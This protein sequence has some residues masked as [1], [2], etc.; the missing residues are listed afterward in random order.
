M[1]FNF[2]TLVIVIGASLVCLGQS[3]VAGPRLGDVE[4]VRVRLQSEADLERFRVQGFNVTNA[5]GA[6]AE[7]HTT[8]EERARLRRAGYRFDSVVE[9]VGEK[10]QSSY[11]TYASLTA[12]LQGFAATYPGITR[13]SSLGLSVEGREL[14]A[15]LISE[16][17]DV[18]EDEPEFKY[19]STMHGDEPVGTELCVNFIEMLLT[20][21]GTDPQITEL[22]NETAIWI[23]PL[24]NPDGHA[25][26]RRG[27]ADGFDLNR[28]FPS[29]GEDYTGTVF[30]GE[31]LGDVGRP[32]EVGHVMRW[33]V[34]NSFVLSA[35]L[36]TGALLVNYPYDN[37]P[38][39]ASGFDAP[40]PDDELFEEIS[41]R[42]SERNPPMFASSLFEDGISNGSDW[43]SITGG[44][45]DWNYRYA[46]CAEV[47]IEL[48]NVKRPS[49]ATLPQLWE[50][51]RE[52]M[53][54][55]LA[56]VHMGVRGI[57][58]D[59][60]SGAPVFAEVT[61]RG[62][63]QPVFSDPDVGDYHRLLLPGRY[64]VR[65]NAPGYLEYRGR[66]TVTEEE[67]ARLDAPLSTGDVDGD[68]DVDAA[69][70]QRVIDAVLG[71]TVCDC[72]VD[73]EGLSATDIQ[74]VVNRALQR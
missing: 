59:R 29:F 74:A 23:V 73:G 4:T 28:S 71:R 35:N 61:I 43:F 63:A 15:L 37:T 65:V 36:H 20:G 5:D 67:T 72:D 32:R 22:V 38:G 45:Q 9:V 44:M 62:N 50:D 2:T 24:M 64:W 1:N 70:V 51:N 27:N 58:S 31:G 39:I 68:G 47:T 48:S 18:E 56:S 14:W 46:G 12:E 13:L 34:A 26:I 41:L 7:L 55:Y 16:H 69:D 53:L 42:Y 19:V 30:D 21:Y 33:T 6:V 54:A 25:D 8:P 60:G 3:D 57:V 10:G 66:V 52:S 40:S 17:P 49:A 11:H